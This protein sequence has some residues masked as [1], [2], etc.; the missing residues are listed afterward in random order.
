[1]SQNNQNP[2]DAAFWRAQGIEPIEIDPNNPESV[3]K[4]VEQVFQQ[5]LSAVTEIQSQDKPKI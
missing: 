1:M 4:G 2:L 5:L 3:E